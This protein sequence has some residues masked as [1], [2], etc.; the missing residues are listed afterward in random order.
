MCVYCINMFLCALYGPV[1]HCV[2]S[3]MAYCFKD[4]K[5]AGTSVPSWYQNKCCTWYRAWL[6]W[7]IN[8]AKHIRQPP[9][10][11]PVKLFLRWISSLQTRSLCV[12]MQ[13]RE[14]KETPQWM[15][16]YVCMNE[17]SNSP[18]ICPFS[19]RPAAQ[20]RLTQTRLSPTPGRPI[21]EAPSYPP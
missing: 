17:S 1:S 10:A 19:S 8:N 20:A 21:S 2:L 13:R 11:S 3:T 16:L 9:F 6:R 12:Y 14:Q 18:R 5:S 4:V 7:L 15:C